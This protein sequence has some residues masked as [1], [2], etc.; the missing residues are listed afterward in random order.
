MIDLADANP[1][2]APLVGRWMDLARPQYAFATIALCLGVGLFAFNAFFVSTALPSAVVDLDGTAMIS[3]SLS[4][5]LIFSIVSGS[6]A[7]FLQKRFGARTM[8]TGAAVAFLAGTLLAA[9][10][11][12]MPALL[13]GRSLQGLSG[14]LIEA[15][16]YAVIPE[17]FPPQLISKVFG[18]E[19][20]VWAAAAFGGPLLAGYVTEW[21]SWRAAFL[22]DLPILL[23]FAALVPVVVPANK[24]ASQGATFPTLR[25]GAISAGMLLVTWSS[26]ANGNLLAAAMVA[27]AAA[28]FI[29]VIRLD[30]RAA[31]RL[32]PRGAFA[33]STPIG[34]GFW[35]ILVMPAA[36]ASASVYL[37]FGIQHL[38][39]Y[40]L[41]YAGAL[42]AIMALSWSLSQFILSSLDR[43][44]L[45]LHAI[46]LGPVM[47]VAGLLGLVAAFRFVDL[48]ALIVAQLLIGSAFGI[49]WGCLSQALMEI[50]PG[51]ERYAT[52]ALLPT[53]Y[54]A[55]F[56]IGAALMGLIGNLA[57]FAS[58]TADSDLQHALIVVF[59]SASALAIGALVAGIRIVTLLRREPSC[60]LP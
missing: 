58:A 44:G 1:S 49:V 28:I 34:L 56:A 21:A 37:V 36:E 27:G 10:A 6:G 7:S 2:A 11:N 38:W 19:A 50:A 13:L 14:G 30:R 3:W 20:V 57:G 22:V 23:L 15:G 25:L 26:I 41:V 32:F 39:H 46:R 12:A 51:E 53:L 59:G 33:V 54:S 42:N 52:S 24:A 60:S 35:I 16:C 48:A 31:A 29:A 5:Y 47:L 17:I 18:A 9:S 55:G 40:S 43:G 8:F 45:R 4:V